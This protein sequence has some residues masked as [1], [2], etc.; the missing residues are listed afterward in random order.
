MSALEEKLERPRDTGG[1]ARRTHASLLACRGY[2]VVEPG[3]VFVQPMDVVSTWKHVGAGK[4]DS[5]SA[6]YEKEEER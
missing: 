5:P 3:V 4:W 1:R 2:R 6:E